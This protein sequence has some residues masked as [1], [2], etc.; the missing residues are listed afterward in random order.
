MRPKFPL[1]LGDFEDFTFLSTG[2]TANMQTPESITQLL[3]SWNSGDRTALNNSY[4]T[5]DRVSKTSKE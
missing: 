3:L 5:T 1:A 4:R 2:R